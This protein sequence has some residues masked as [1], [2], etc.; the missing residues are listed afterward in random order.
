MSQS[1]LVVEDDSI[2]AAFVAKLLESIDFQVTVLND[3]SNIMEVTRLDRPDLILLDYHL[4]G[5]DGLMALRQL[6]KNRRSSPVIMMTADND[7]KVAVE[8][9]RAG[10][11]EFIP[12]PFDPDYFRIVVKRAIDNS[13]P[14]IRDNMLKLMKYA[15]HLSDCT[16]HKE[17]NTECSC[18]LKE[19]IVDVTTSNNF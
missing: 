2:M 16:S 1:I 19:V 4:P 3:A 18:G 11:V 17:G 9:F 5:I 8:C 12:K 15:H 7:Q 10:A 13:S 6:K 14:T